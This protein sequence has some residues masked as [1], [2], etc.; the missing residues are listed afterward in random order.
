[1]PLPVILYET[2]RHRTRYGTYHHRDQRL[3][4]LNLPLIPPPSNACLLPPPHL[5]FALPYDIMPGSRL[6]PEPAT[7]PPVPPPRA[8]QGRPGGRQQV[9]D[10][11]HTWMVSYFF[12][13]SL[14]I[15]SSMVTLLPFVTQ[16][17]GSNGGHSSPLPLLPCM[18]SFFIAG[19]V[20]RFVPWSTLV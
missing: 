11:P 20:E 9:R 18:T 3:Y 16:T 14:S 13:K 8:S 5:F 4:H 1:M 10:A 15:P 2:L 7:V 12:A 19:R 17:P 6:P